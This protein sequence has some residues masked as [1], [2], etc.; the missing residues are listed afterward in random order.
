M[1]SAA[2]GTTHIWPA[3]IITSLAL[4]VTASV[5][6]Y[7]ADASQD[8]RT[9]A[10]QKQAASRADVQ[11]L[12]ERLDRLERI[13]GDIL[14]TVKPEVSAEELLGSMDTRTIE[15]SA[16]SAANTLPTNN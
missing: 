6:F 3:A 5:A 15:P 4:I 16:E 2:R 1:I 8:Q 12:V 7:S 14:V 11:M 9:K 13:T 10:L